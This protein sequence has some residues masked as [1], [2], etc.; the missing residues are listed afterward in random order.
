[1]NIKTKASLW[2]KEITHVLKSDLPIKKLWPKSL[3]KCNA[4]IS[5]CKQFFEEN[6]ET[7]TS[8]S[9][10]LICSYIVSNTRKRLCKQVLR[11]IKTK[12]KERKEYAQIVIMTKWR[13]AHVF[14]EVLKINS[15]P[16]I[17]IP[18]NSTL[19]FFSCLPFLPYE[20]NLQDVLRQ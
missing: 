4:K 6:M 1:M 19:Y 18:C 13:A 20:N 11:E 17:S 9:S 14:K 5:W 12:R 15:N 7:T 2:Q 8:F 10:H 3:G 16:Y